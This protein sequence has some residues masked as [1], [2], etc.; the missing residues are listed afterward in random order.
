MPLIV[1]IFLI[2]LG[3]YIL[4]MLFAKL[5]F[6]ASIK[7]GIKNKTVFIEEDRN[8]KKRYTWVNSG[9]I[10]TGEGFDEHHIVNVINPELKAK[11]NS[12]KAKAKAKT[13]EQDP[14]KSFKPTLVSHSGKHE[15]ATFDTYIAGVNHHCTAEDVGAF[16]GAVVPDP[17]NAYDPNAVKVI[18]YDGKLVGFIPKD[19]ALQIR[20]LLKTLG[21]TELPCVGYIKEGYKYPFVSDLKIMSVSDEKALYYT[22]IDYTYDI[23]LQED[24]EDFIPMGVD[25]PG[26]SFEEKMK[27]LEEE[28]DKIENYNEVS[29]R[30]DQ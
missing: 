30:E 6:G 23:L 1:K 10:A 24:D 12:V 14:L 19:H 22:I 18:R 29:L 4:F 5:V 20:L 27:F 9:N 26:D 16:I 25:I 17:A 8:G 11:A 28:C 13:R 21:T 3:I 2:L 7:K 15:A